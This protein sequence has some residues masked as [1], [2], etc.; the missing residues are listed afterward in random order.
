MAALAVGAVLPAVAQVDPS[1]AWRTW[2]TA[3]FR[4]HATAEHRNAA[5]AAS[6]EAERAY[7]L[8]AGELRPPRGIVDV[9]L[10]D[11]T[12]VS[13]G[14]AAIFPSN[15]LFIFLV[16]PGP[17]VSLGYYD[18]WL[19]VVL[20]HELAHLFHLD[21][22]DGIWGVL[23]HVFGRAPGLFPNT[24]HPSWVSEGLATYYESRFTL[25]GRV[26]GGF[27]TQVVRAAA[28][29]GRWPGPDDATLTVSAWPAGTRPY[30]W[31][32]RFFALEAAEHGDSVVPRFVDRA[33]RQLWP[34]AVS[35]PLR[36]AGADPLAAGWERLRARAGD[37]GPHAPAG[38]VITR[39]LFV[40][41][42]IALSPDGSA[43]A[44]VH[45]DGRAVPR[46]VVRNAADGRV[47][48]SR[49]LTGGAEVAWVAET[50]YVT[51]LDFATPVEVWSDLYRWTPDGRWTR[52]TH[53]ARLTTPF[54]A[55]AGAVGVSTTLTGDRSVATV[56]APEWTP[57]PFPVPAADE[58]AS[59]AVSRDGRW[60]AGV[61]LRDGRWD[62]VWWP[63][64]DPGAV[65]SVTDDGALEGDPAWTP[66]GSRLLFFSERSGLPQIYDY[67]P[68]T[69]ASR[70]RT[71]EPTGAREPQ[72]GPDGTLFYSSVLGDGFAVLR[73]AGADPAPEPT[74]SRGPPG[75]FVSAPA[76]VARETAYRPWPALIPRYWIPIGAAEGS[77]GYFVGALS[78]GS[79]PIGRTA[80]GATVLVAPT[81]GR[82]E[83][84]LRVEHRRWKVASL[85]V[86]ISQDWEPTLGITTDGTLVRLGE[87][88]RRIDTGL[89][90]S[91]RRWRTAFA[92][93]I[94]AELNARAL[95]DDDT[96]AVTP[97]ELPLF[98]GGVL[99]FRL[100]HN[101][102]PAL[103]ISPE[104]G[105]VLDG[106]LRRRW[107][108]AG[109][110]WSYGLRGGVSGYLALPLPGFAHWVLA[111]RLSAAR[112]GGPAPE[113]FGIGG[114]SGDVFQIVPGYTVG[115][116]RRAFPLRGYPRAGSFTRVVVGMVELRLP[117]VLVSAGLWKLPVVL[118]R[119]SLAAFVE[120]G[121][122]WNAGETPAPTAFRDVG[123][124]AVFDL[125]VSYDVP[126][127]V[128]V[129]AAV[130]LTSGL[131][132]A[133]GDA[134]FYVAFGPS[135]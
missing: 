77:A 6:R 24:Y 42:Q 59:F 88:E 102:R 4:I 123:A 67:R 35:A 40:E 117:L 86:G 91:W 48:T 110:E 27:H 127:R 85:D 20:T 3:H 66:D 41:P 80:Y 29:G 120:M 25:G 8:L 10:F 65:V 115:A 116:G 78:G 129:G 108:L 21:R 60:V 105:I 23:Q 47:R 96:L 64:E 1:G 111:T 45:N 83:G 61:R 11:N 34:L 99:A 95:F 51:Q 135:F 44:Y 103:A 43:I 114:E 73:Q 70:R 69:G 93:R 30:A 37:G 36:R 119:V 50:L 124:E 32:S 92:T 26:R 56:S 133:R 109:P 81:R 57:R 132:V 94:G 134:R 28:A 68:A 87:R 130:P 121:G 46:L 89:T 58:W 16:P 13:N 107:A 113:R 22:A 33:S 106:S 112:S 15:R 84:G 76:V 97:P 7:E 128:R 75:V 5:L 52:L 54:A 122:G 12:D 125:G 19:R 38:A 14:A 104:D 126:L 100:A 71:D 17:D 39:G 18:A 79:D 90:L 82:W 53:G 55:G 131:G 62:L 72:E 74:L 2:R 49:R 118:D 31:G 101:S 98:G 9:A 63:R